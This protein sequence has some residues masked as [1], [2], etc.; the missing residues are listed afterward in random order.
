MIFRILNLPVVLLN[1]F[2]KSTV[3]SIRKYLLKLY[4]QTKYPH[5]RLFDRVEMDLESRLSKYNVIFS[6]VKIISSSIGA[7]TYLQENSIVMNSE[8][9][10]FC[11]IAMN[12][13]IG[14][15][16]HSLSCFS[17]HP[18]FYLNNSPLI[19]KFSDDNDFITSKRTHIGNDVWIGH[20]ALIMNGVRIG[21]GAVIGA[22][23]VVTKDVP[24]YA[25]VV[26][27]PAK[28]LRHRFDKTT[29]NK[30][31]ESKWWDNEDDWL[32]KNYKTLLMGNHKE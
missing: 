1:N 13:F 22:G 15:P 3:S 27:T 11:S 2:Y 18:A 23:A 28:I 32:K 20:G 25:I 19:K 26:G 29:I 21:D 24:D 12:T 9:G 10:K 5:C 6:N 31:I 17:T 30:L 8:I 4:I 7:H 16:Q 14:L